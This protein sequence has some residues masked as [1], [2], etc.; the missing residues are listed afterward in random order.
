MFKKLNLNIAFL[1]LLPFVTSGQEVITGL[2]TNISILNSDKY[3]VKAKGLAAGPV[4]LPFFD[5][6]SGKNIFP[7]ADRWTDN[8]VFINNTYSDRQPTTGIATFDAIDNT[9]RLYETATSYGFEADHLTSQPVNLNLSP[10]DNIWLSFLYQPGGLGDP[11][12]LR[13]SLTLQFFASAENRWYS[14]WRAEGTLQQNFKSVILRIDNPRFLNSGFQ[15]RFVNWA[16]LASA[17]GDPS[18][19]GN[20]DQWNIDYVYLDKN[21]NSADTSLADVAFRRPI[22]SLLKTH[23]AMPWKQFKEISL[24]EM[25]SVIPIH[26][27]N[28]DIIVRNVTRNFII[29]DL[30][31]NT[32]SHSFSAGATNINPLTN[33][34]YDANLIYTF[35]STGNDSALFGITCYLI[36]DEFD[37]KVNDTIHY[38]QVFSNYFAFDDGTSE[39]GYGVT[40]QGSRNAMA[41]YRFKSFIQDTI[42]AI[43]ICFNDSYLNSNL[44]AFDLVVWNDISD[45]P[46][47][48]LYSADEQMVVK[49]ADLNG[50]YTYNLPDPVMVNGVFYVGWRQR[51]ETF[52]NAGYDVNTPNNNRQ[53]YWLNGVWQKSQAPGSIMIRPVVGKSLK[54]TSVD[55]TFPE[56]KHSFSIWPNPASDFINLYSDELALSR[57]AFVTIID[58]QGRELIRVPYSERIDI[59][60]LHPGIYTVIASSNGRATGYIRLVKTR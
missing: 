45:L 3:A 32:I 50:F 31:T 57:T 15:F 9:G 40:G 2:Q 4:Q 26:Y 41:A 25:G 12:E 36:T 5:D 55:D 33:V 35:N 20:C 6:F 18:M 27:R 52:L 16:S 23:E 48:I 10:S 54:P 46:G 58:F 37:P 14:V 38:N 47:D 60:G 22:R 44:R 30:Y 59:S 29:K 13:D 53:F 21:R 24:Q 28:N 19:I 17:T 51:S 49:G 56:G 8:F 7:A 11:P 34:D 43:R 42:R 39:G 1:L